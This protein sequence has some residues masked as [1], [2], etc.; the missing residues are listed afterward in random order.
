MHT[1][2]ITVKVH[3][4]LKEMTSEDVEEFI[5]LKVNEGHFVE[6]LTLTPVTEMPL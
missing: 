5:M 2:I 4:D 6:V 3:D 1:F